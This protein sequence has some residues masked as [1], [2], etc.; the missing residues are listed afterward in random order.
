LTTT[1]EK[2]IFII[3]VISVSFFP[4]EVEGRVCITVKGSTA[5]RRTNKMEPLKPKLSPGN[6]KLGKIHNISLP[7][8]KTC[9]KGVPCA[10]GKCYA[11]KAWRQYPAVREAWQNNLQCYI[12]DPEGYFKEIWKYIWKR[13][14]KY[15]RWH[16]G[17]DIPDGRYID[18]MIEVANMCPSTQFLAYTK[19]YGYF[20]LR[21][22][23]NLRLVVSAW[24][25]HPLPRN[26]G[27]PVAWLSHD[28]RIPRN[29]DIIECPNNC[30]KCLQCF[31][32]TRDVVFHIH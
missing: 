25:G 31:G 20:P 10:N 11:L 24:P 19:R 17:G 9:V 27:A 28:H 3:L 22:P 2:N 6:M 15:F 8:I 18:G 32:T 16:V 7:P 14:A 13:R 30:D 5:K 29:R 26:L 1:G 23:D 12:E 4:F 21:L